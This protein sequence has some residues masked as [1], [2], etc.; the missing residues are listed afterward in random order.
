MHLK[1]AEAAAA[2]AAQSLTDTV[3]AL[4]DELSS[5]R[6]AAALRMAR[7][8]DGWTGPVE[9]TAQAMA[10]AAA[11][12]PQDIR[13]AI[14][15]A[16]DNIRAFAL[17]QRASATDIAVELRPGLWAGHR[18]I[19]VA[20][21]GCYVP[22]GRYAHVAS[23]L[24]TVATARAAGVGHVAAVTPPRP[25]A[26][27]GVPDAVL[28][29]LQVAGAD[30]VLALGGV[31]AV[32][33]LAYGL[34]GLPPADILAGPGNPF[35]A[36]AKRL[37]YGPVGIDMMAGPTDVLVLADATA[38]ARLV[39]VDLIAQ[40][41]HGANSPVWLVTDSAP[42]AARVAELAPQLAADLPEPNR[43]AALA[44]WGQHA[45]IIL[46]EGR[47]AMAAEAD[48]I[49]PEHLQVMAAE[50][51]WWRDRLRSYGALFLGAETTVAFGDKA[52]GPNHVLP[53]GGAARHTGG[54]SALKFLRTVT[55]Q[56]VEP[57]A[58][59]DLARATATIARIEGMEGHARSAEARLTR[60]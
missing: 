38:D 21:A 6:E 34:F 18:H 10:E 44:A 28:F 48:R 30:R 53:T 7:E 37:L 41:E 45:E 27:A 20:A 60:P 36:E 24:M 12:V 19:P 51:G 16:H 35:V 50:P 1:R 56:R 58:L 52:A 55:W 8:F 17:A 23:A 11:R 57:A 14:L 32:A 33:A 40:A 43:A 31:Q 42:L 22:G 2:G 9:V 47:E 25:G 4:L 49:G 59:S 29:A 3:R 46:C 26:P 15:W 13:D 5:G 39:A 54:L